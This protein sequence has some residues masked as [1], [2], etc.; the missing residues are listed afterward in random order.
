MVYRSKR[1]MLKRVVP[2]TVVVTTKRKRRNPADRL[3]RLTFNSEK[4]KNGPFPAVMRAVFPYADNNPAW[5]YS[6]G[7]PNV[8]TYRL[9][10]L[11]DPNYTGTGT[12][13]QYL[14]T[15]MGAE[16]GNAPYRW[17]KVVNS[18]YIVTISNRSTDLTSI[19]RFSVTVTNSSTAY[20]ATLEQAMMDSQ[21]RVSGLL[22]VATSGKNT[23][24][25]RGTVSMKH[26]LGAEIF[27]QLSAAADYDESPT[28]GYAVYMHIAIWPID[29]ATNT[30][31]TFVGRTEVLCDAILFDKNVDG[32]A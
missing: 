24:T 8:Y 3:K 1:T 23:Q 12:S 2:K 7:V 32:T 15:L 14:T 19:S 28:G 26:V 13:V 5:G 31:N 4:G 10:S 29:E 16:N 20:P 30:L 18:K 11:Y 21:T 6:A 27:N 9:N 25:L 17:Y 22:N